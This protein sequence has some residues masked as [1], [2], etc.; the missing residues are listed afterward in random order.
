MV[1]SSCRL[2]EC[3]FNVTGQ[4]VLNRPVEECS[5]WTEPDEPLGGNDVDDEA[6]GGSHAA[7]T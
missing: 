3:T 7:G 6:E 4:C 5:T 2:S 1:Q